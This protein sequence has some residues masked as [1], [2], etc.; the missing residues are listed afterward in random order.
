VIARAEALWHSGVRPTYN[1]TDWDWGAPTH[2]PDRSAPAP[3]APAPPP[4]PPPPAPPPGPINYDPFISQDPDYIAALGSIQRQRGDTILNYGDAT[5]VSGVDEATA[6]NAKANPY[7]VTAQLR[8]LLAGN[9]GAVGNNA[10]AHG[11]LFSGAFKQGQ[12]NE[13]GAGTNRSYDATR[14]F[15]NQLG[16][17]AEQQQQAYNDAY[18]RIVGQ[19]G[20][21]GGTGPAPAPPA[22]PAPTAQIAAPT[23][24]SQPASQLGHGMAGYQQIQKPKPK[25]KPKPTGY[26]YSSNAASG[27]RRS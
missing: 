1:G 21:L 27:A 17:L 10:N 20:Q 14:A 16:G 6:A 9:L 7:S 3:E 19:A 12:Q 4:P 26:F 8:K 13:L 23:V 18:K 11:A 24:A 25:P 5:G 22:A 15:Q 2:A